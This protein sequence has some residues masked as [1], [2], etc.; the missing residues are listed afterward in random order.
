MDIH[1]PE[2]DGFEASKIIKT[3]ENINITTPIYGLSADVFSKNNQLYSAYFADFLFKPLEIEK[4]H[5]AL[6]NA[7]N[8]H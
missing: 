1:M 3:T 8:V 6:I 5:A 2:M 7:I 4:L